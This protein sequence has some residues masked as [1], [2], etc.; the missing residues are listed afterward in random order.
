MAWC[1]LLR[2]TKYFHCFYSTSINDLALLKSQFYSCFLFFQISAAQNRVYLNAGT[3][4]LNIN[5]EDYEAGLKGI[6]KGSG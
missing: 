3:L 1:F 6:N 5:D 4:M 2:F